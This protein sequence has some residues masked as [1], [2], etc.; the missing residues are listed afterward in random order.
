MNLNISQASEGGH[1]RLVLSG[2]IDEGANFSTLRWPGIK[3]VTFDL[4]QVS[5]YT[6]LGLKLWITFLTDIPATIRLH[7]VKCSIA[8]V[9]QLNQMA[10][11]TG[12]KPVA[13]DS[14]QVPYYCETCDRGDIAMIHTK[15]LLRSTESDLQLPKRCCNVCG[16]NQ[17]PEAPA[18]RYLMF[19]R[20]QSAVSEEA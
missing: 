2:R 4:E 15:D 14:F 5:L 16:R 1:L 6:S 7:F 13:V 9:H 18:N 10:S 19:L 20:R 3:Q 8:T 17:A 12:G 11:F